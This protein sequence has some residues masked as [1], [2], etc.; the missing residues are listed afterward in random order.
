MN[1]AY[2]LENVS[3]RIGQAVLLDD[4]SLQVPYGEL[5]ALVGPNGAGKST[6]LGALSGDI[7]ASTGRV[8]LNGEDV[9]RM[10]A[11]TLARH[12]AVLLQANR[13]SFAYTVQ[14]V[15]EMGAAPWQ[16]D[17]RDEDAI[18][19]S[20]MRRTDI[21]HLADRA[22]GSLSGGEQARASFARVL[23]QDTPVVMLDEPTAALDLRHQEELL[24]IAR[25]LADEGRAVVVVLHDLS[26]AAA[27]AD[28]VAMLHRGRLVAHGHPAEVMTEVRIET[29]YGAPVAVITD[30]INGHPLVIPRRR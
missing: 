1:A 15:V 14:Q 13:V 25:G 29:V 21:E 22:Y 27:F 26:L 20:A 3:Y 5:L 11:R 19:L 17:A 28:E 23:V 4:V 12:R 9:S 10:R 30:P 24:R 7:S 16:A 8:L 18:V 2:E 6:L